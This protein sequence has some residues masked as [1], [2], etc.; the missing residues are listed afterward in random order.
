MF[1]TKPTI[2]LISKIELKSEKQDNP[3]E[4]AILENV[5]IENKQELERKKLS[6]FK[7]R[8]KQRL[9]LY[10][11]V[12]NK[13]DKDFKIYF[14]ISKTPLKIKLS[15]QIDTEAKEKSKS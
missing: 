14:N 8:V 1:Q 4:K 13:I 7:L 11:H 15:S 3:F 6:D 12:E 2:N 9:T 10:K 5:R